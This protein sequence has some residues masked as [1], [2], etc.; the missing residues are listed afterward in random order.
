MNRL[1]VVEATPSPTG[2]IADHRLPLQAAGVGAFARALAAALG[3][4]G[5]AAAGDTSPFKAWLDPL[6]RDLQA[7]RGKSLVIVGDEQPAEVHALGHAI[8]QALGNAGQTVTFTE[9]IEARPVD[10]LG[11]LW[12]LVNDM[13]AGRVDTLLVIDANPVYTAPVDM[14][15]ADR[16]SKVRMRIHLGLHQDETA[17]LCHW[18]IPMAHYLESWSD[19]RAADGTVT[20]IQPLIAPLYNGRTAHELIATMT[21]QAGQTPYEIVRA[22]WQG[23]AAQLGGANFEKFW[24][25]ALHDGMIAGTAAAARTVTAGPVTL[26]TPPPAKGL[27]I[28]FRADPSVFDGRF[29]NNGWLQELPKPNSKLTWDNA[30]LVSPKTA[31]RLGVS[32]EDVIELR[33][34][35]RRVTAPVWI[36][37]GQAADSITVYL[38]YGRTNAGTVGN[39]TGFNAY[40]LRTSHAIWA[41]HGLEV[42]KTGQ[43]YPLATTQNQQTMEGREIVR[44]ATLEE[45][46][47]KPDF[48]HE[49]AEA[50]ARDMTLYPEYKY[51]GHAWAMAI[52]LSTCIGCN[53]CV[54]ACNSENNIPVVGKTEVSRGHKM[55]W[56]RVDRYHKGDAEQPA[57]FNA[58]VPCMQCEN[59]PC[60]VVCPVAA[61]SH[62]SEGLN[63]MVYNRCVGTRYCSNNCPYKVRRFNFFLYQDW[64]TPSLKML[65]NPD[66][67]VRSRGVMEKCTY[68]VQRINAAKIEAEKE[69]RG[70]RDGEIVTACEA[71]CPTRAIVFGD[72]NNPESRVVKLKAEPLNYG[73]LEDLNTRP[74]TT[75]LASVRNPNPEMP[76]G[77]KG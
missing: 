25:K 77:E 76:G 63:D 39:G 17:S 51:T 48:A 68:C 42:G 44:A 45:F 20:I 75:Y 24:R 40:T 9:P 3:V 43:R 66:V 46:K 54:V 60:E 18:Q 5:A 57:A 4:T 65:R 49:R 6:V 67:S 16:M 7:H 72:L 37:P 15:F 47:R 41:S 73:M 29:A 59:A 12:D 35:G 34:R 74:R 27:E 19:A 30:A 14:K 62:S 23:R 64:N 71:A 13:D 21:K 36:L 22:Y 31:E 70:V 38:G 55:H 8:N 32:K 1:Y 10:E 2:S 33:Y 61:T 28:V 26:G 56:L 52:D 11:T 53:A 50:P 58:P 69:N